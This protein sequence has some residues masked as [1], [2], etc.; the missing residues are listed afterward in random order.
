MQWTGGL[1]AGFSTQTPW[2]SAGGNLLTNNVATM[3]NNP[4]SLLSHY[5]KLVQLRNRHAALRRGYLLN[6][7]NNNPNVL[8]Y[9]R[10]YEQEGVLVCSNFGADATGV[11]ASLSA[12]T[13]TAGDYTVTD[14]STNQALGSLNINSSGG[15]SNWQ[16][17]GNDLGSRD[18]RMLG[19]S[20]KTSALRPDPAIK[21]L[22]LS[23]SPNPVSDEGTICI[24]NAGAG[25]GTLEVLDVSG[26][27]VYKGPMAGGQV[28][29]STGHW[30]P[31][32]YFVRVT[33]DGRAGSVRLVKPD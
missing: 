15:F 33:V 19:L 18:T 13:L 29:L 20:P 28:M 2:I 22:T 31:G 6:V 24:V 9:A 8:A 25:V 14:L 17:P 1:N 5:K 11:T 27:Q 12:S 4:T 16:V 26:R 10:I 23:V 32:V 3:S 21:A 30:E 7:P